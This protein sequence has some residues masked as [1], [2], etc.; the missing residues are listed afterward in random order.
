MSFHVYVETHAK[1]AFCVKLGM[2][3][4]QANVKMTA[5]HINYRV[6]RKLI[7]K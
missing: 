3:P 6:G 4:T 1:I 7:F 2:M 5:A